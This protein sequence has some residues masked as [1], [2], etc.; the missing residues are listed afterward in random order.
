MALQQLCVMPFA[1]K[2]GGRHACATPTEHGETLR[3]VQTKKR[4]TRHATVKPTVLACTR[5]AC[6]AFV[7]Y[8]VIKPSPPPFFCQRIQEQESSLIERAVRDSRSRQFTLAICGVPTRCCSCTPPFKFVSLVFF[9]F[10]Y[11]RARALDC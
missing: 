5:T 2:G 6:V 4:V 8:F 11:F 1:E 10:H 9:F 3:S 7:L